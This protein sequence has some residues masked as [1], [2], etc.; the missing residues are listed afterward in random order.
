MGVPPL[1]NVTV[2][3]GAT[4]LLEVV[5]SAVRVTGLPAG[6]VVGLAE[7]LLVV[8]AGVMVRTSVAGALAV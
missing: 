2:P 5:T 6:T 4:P 3:D 7:T 8:P 1:K